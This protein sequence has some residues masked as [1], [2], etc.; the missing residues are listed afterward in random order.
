MHPTNE[1]ATLHGALRAA[2]LDQL[3]ES[4]GVLGDVGV[5]SSERVHATRKHIKRARALLSLAGHRRRLRRWQSLLAMVGRSLGVVRDPVAQ[6]RTWAKGA[7]RFAEPE[8][9]RIS[10]ALH[11]REQRFAAP[12]REERRLRRAERVLAAVRARLVDALNNDARATPIAHAAGASYRRARRA[13]RRASN[14]SNAEQV[15]SLRRA[16]KRHQYQMQFLELLWRKPLK[17]Q[18]KELGRLTELLGSHHDVACL[19]RLLQP[20]GEGVTSELDA[21][22]RELLGEALALAQ[23]AFS[24]RPSAFV[25]RMR[26]YVGAQPV[27]RAAA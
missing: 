13:L 26:G 16:A 21:W 12:E 11:Q 4:L 7:P 10:D 3:D 19:E 9:S 20:R 22:Q 14:G 23:L 15:H 27:L 5:S 6:A 24:E 18:R 17:A 1:P 8:R 2:I 25:R